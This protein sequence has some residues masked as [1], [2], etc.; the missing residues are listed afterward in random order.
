MRL[1][2]NNVFMYISGHHSLWMGLATLLNN[3]NNIKTF[4][5]NSNG[6]TEKPK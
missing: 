6:P 1:T 3:I 2:E 5:L 4:K